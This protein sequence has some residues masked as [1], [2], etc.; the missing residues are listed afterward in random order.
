MNVIHFQPF[1][2]HKAVCIYRTHM[3]H[4]RQEEATY[5]VTFR[6]ADALPV[7]VVESR[8]LELRAWLKAHGIEYDAAGTWKTCLRSLPTEA[9][10]AYSRLAGS[11]IDG[12][13]DKGS[14]SCALRPKEI[15]H[16]V[17][18]SLLCF[19]GTRLSCGDFV[20]MPN[21]VHWLVS[22]HAGYELEGILRSVKSYTAAGINRIRHGAGRVWQTG[23]YDHIVRD[24]EELRHFRR[25]IADNP[26]KAGLKDDVCLLHRAVWK[27]P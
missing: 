2:P 18:H 24:M 11:H 16:L 25:Y 20:V 22:P 21:H 8:R 26:A 10:R 13:L 12:Y 3:P 27:T 7:S 4:W 6:L 23:N 9:Q 1:D 5:F 19:H 14:G 17:G 15:A